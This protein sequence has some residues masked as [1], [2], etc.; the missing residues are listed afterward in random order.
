[1]EKRY[2]NCESVEDIAKLRKY[3]TAGG[4]VDIERAS[5]TFVDDSRKTRIGKI[6]LD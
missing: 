5:Y 1:M 4:E 2:P 6:T 3:V